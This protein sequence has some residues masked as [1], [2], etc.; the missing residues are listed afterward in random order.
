MNRRKDPQDRHDGDISLRGTKWEWGV[1]V[2]GLRISAQDAREDA[3]EIRGECPSAPKGVIERAAK[4]LD[5]RARRFSHM[6]DLIA[7]EA[8]IDEERQV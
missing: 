2:E 1:I 6:A 8:D 4:E 5:E 3:R 7:I